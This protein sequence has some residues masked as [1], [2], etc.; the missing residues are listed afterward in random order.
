MAAIRREQPTT[1]PWFYLCCVLL[2]SNLLVYQWAY[3]TSSSLDPSHSYDLLSVTTKRLN[4]GAD[5][6]GSSAA[7]DGTSSTPAEVLRNPLVIPRGQAMPLPSIRT[8]NDGSVADVKRSIYGGAGDKKHLGG[9]T[10][11]DT[12]GISPRAW[13]WMVQRLNIQS[14]LDVGCGRGISTTWFYFHGLQILCVEGSHDAREKTMLPDPDTQMVEHDFARGPWWPGKTFDAVW[15]VEFL[16][17]V[18][19]AFC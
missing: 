10:D 13:K 5:S 17:H 3:A 8:D 2:L 14:V 4:S 15:C 6:Y 12:A 16:E 18:S 19:F 11:I 7:A 9:F 1:V